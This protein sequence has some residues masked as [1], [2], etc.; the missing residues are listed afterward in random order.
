WISGWKRRG[1]ISSSG[2]DVLNR[3]LW[4]EMDR[5]RSG[6]DVTWTWVRGHAGNAN[7]E[8]ADR[9]AGMAAREQKGSYDE[10][11]LG[12][13]AMAAETTVKRSGAFTIDLDLSVDDRALASA[14]RA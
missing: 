7:N 2:K 10:I 4:E 12:D 9:L 3:D 14:V 13:V 5:E 6:L 1:W 8:V 11:T